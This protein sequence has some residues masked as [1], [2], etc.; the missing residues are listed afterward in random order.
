MLED[1]TTHHLIGDLTGL[2]MASG[3][4]VSSHSGHTAVLSF[5]LLF[6]HAGGL[7]GVIWGGWHWWF[8][9][10]L[11]WGFQTLWWCCVQPWECLWLV[12]PGPS[13]QLWTK[14]YVHRKASWL[15][16][17]GVWAWRGKDAPEGRVNVSSWISSQ[18]QGQKGHWWRD[19]GN[20]ADFVYS[21]LQIG[22][23]MKKH[24]NVW[25]NDMLKWTTGTQN[26]VVNIF[27]VL[28]TMWQV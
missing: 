21:L 9:P 11:R 19:Q 28:G 15:G 20:K 6:W 14:H 8:M 5:P 12:L 10:C 4:A 25:M 26:L 22:L 3:T 24:L 17:L 1:W 7:F 2:G 27:N 18:I 13:A 16:K 23:G